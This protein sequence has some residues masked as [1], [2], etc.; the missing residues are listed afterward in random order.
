MSA[1]APTHLC[2]SHKQG[3]KEKTNPFISCL[4]QNRGINRAVGGIVVN[5]QAWSFIVVFSEELTELGIH[6]FKPSQ[7][8]DRKKIIIIGKHEK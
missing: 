8:P 5:F 7:C 4:T 2:D 1:G 3:A 6:T